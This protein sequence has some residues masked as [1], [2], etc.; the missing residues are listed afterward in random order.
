[1][2]IVDLQPIR[3]LPPK[4]REASQCLMQ[5]LPSPPRSSSTLL[6]SLYILSSVVCNIPLPDIS[7]LVKDVLLSDRKFVETVLTL[8]EIH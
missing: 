7:V 3:H 6:Q 8:R 2:E 5:A 4:Q 1:M